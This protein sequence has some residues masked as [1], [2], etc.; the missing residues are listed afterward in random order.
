MKNKTRTT[1][2]ALAHAMAHYSNSPTLQ[3]ARKH[4]KVVE[5]C[6]SQVDDIG[7]QRAILGAIILE[8]G[9]A[10]R[11][12]RSIGSRPRTDR[13]AAKDA[14]PFHE[15][16]DQAGVAR[17]L[18]AA[19]TDHGA[20]PLAEEM[21]ANVAN[22]ARRQS[23]P[24]D[25]TRRD[26]LSAARRLGVAEDELRSTVDWSIHGYLTGEYERIVA[27]R[28]PLYLKARAGASR[29]RT[30]RLEKQDPNGPSITRA[31]TAL[32]SVLSIGPTV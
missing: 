18:A 29:K 25:P 24:T 2:D 16:A 3:K 10:A 30:A 21:A 22:L 1:E 19:G 4:L 17:P 32:A 5:R 31:R 15:K 7:W 13:V 26:F 14:H 27:A 28:K 8:L 12:L 20:H 9:E 23:A 6:M 11:D